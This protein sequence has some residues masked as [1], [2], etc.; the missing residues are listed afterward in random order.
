MVAVQSRLPTNLRD[1]VRLQALQATG[2]LD[3][4]P[5]PAL[6]RVTRLVCRSLRM[7]A[8]LISLV[9]GE[10][11]IFKS[12][13][14]IPEPWATRRE[15]PLSHSICRHA[16]ESG[17]VL[18]ASDTRAVP[19]LHDNPAITELGM[20]AYAGIPLRDPSGQ[21]LGTLCAID[22]QPRQWTLEELGTLHDLAATAEAEV[23]R[24]RQAGSVDEAAFRLLVENGWDVVHVLA[25][26]GVV[27]YVSPAVGMA[28]MPRSWTAPVSCGTRP[29]GR[30]G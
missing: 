27:R 1:P 3:T 21:V 29:G 28:R 19:E 26:E 2:L 22:Q 10:R 30:S 8:A 16:V 15:V 11:Q 24:S 12:A 17:E 13:A 6:D 9:D 4:G 18:L 23:Q 20:I 14:G 25:A 5:E 7:P